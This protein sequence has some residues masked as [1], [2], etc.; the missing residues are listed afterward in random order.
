[1]I[2]ITSRDFDLTDAIRTEIQAMGPNLYKHIPE[3]EKIKVT[4]SKSAPDVFHVHMQA[5]YLGEEI[6][7]DHESH[8][9][10]KALELCKDHFVRITDKRRNKIQEKW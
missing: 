1:M 9:F 3:S 10:H 6:V 8:N 4:L 5:H 7:C 2:D